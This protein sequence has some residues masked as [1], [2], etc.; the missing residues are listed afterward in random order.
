M[1]DKDL[2]IHITGDPASAVNALNR[3]QSKMTQ[4]NS[5]VQRMSIN[6]KQMAK[7]FAAFAGVAGFYQTIKMVGEFD[8]S[9]RRLAIDSNMTAS[10]M[11]TM[12]EKILAA[13]QATGQAPEEVTRLAKAAYQA[14]HDIGFVT[15]NL[16]LMADAMEASGAAP[17]DIGEAMGSFRREMKATAPEMKTFFGTMLTYGKTGAAKS[18]LKNMLPQLPAIFEAA[19]AIYGKSLTMDKLNSIITETMFTG[20]PAAALKAMR[21]LTRNTKFMRAI[22][23]D[24]SKGLPSFDEIFASVLKHSKNRAAAMNELRQILGPAAI[25]LQRLIDENEIYKKSIEGL[26]TKKAF[27]RSPIASYEESMNRLKGVW[28][29]I[30]QKALAPGIEA[31]A[32]SLESL[33]PETIKSLGD[34]LALFGKSVGYVLGGLLRIPEAI[35]EAASW[36]DWWNDKRISGSEKSMT[37]PSGQSTAEYYLQHPGELITDPIKRKEFEDARRRGEV[38]GAGAG[39]AEPGRALGN[40]P[41][42]APANVL[43]PANAP[44]N[45]LKVNVYDNRVTAELKSDKGN[46][47]TQ[48]TKKPLP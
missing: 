15:E 36:I 21:R 5:S 16:S 32:K 45:V 14:S 35:K 41:A 25:D 31:F 19:K 24:L 4:V 44:A 30:A 13:V 34:A 22:G 2:A 39:E 17:E 48:G 7:G 47:L 28:L 11:L 1:A 33:S 43:L 27:D 23:I 3:V 6:W 10:Q 29:T 9:I 20:H 46:Q 38:F 40:L 26:D 12:K 42:N 8:D 37:V 18:N